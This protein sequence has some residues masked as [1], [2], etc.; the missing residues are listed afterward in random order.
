MPQELPKV[1]CSLLKESG[2]ASLQE[3]VQAAEE[4]SG[5]A[6]GLGWY[7]RECC[8]STMP[9]GANL[10]AAYPE[11]RNIQLDTPQ[12]LIAKQ[13]C[14]RPG[15]TG[16]KD[17]CYGQGG[18]TMDRAI[19]RSDCQYQLQNNTAGYWPLP[20]DQKVRVG[21]AALQPLQ[22]DKR[23]GANR[24]SPRPLASVRGAL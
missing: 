2:E 18:E 11:L 15:L 19:E 13:E 12:G 5:K 20:G 4:V 17:P 8:P 23:P 9:A 24:E 21:C 6:L 14:K 3:L 1:A 10:Q 7:S 16:P 22:T